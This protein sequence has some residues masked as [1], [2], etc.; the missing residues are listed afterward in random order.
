ME[1]SRVFILFQK[2]G[3]DEVV[4]AVAS[5]EE[6]ED[7]RS[8]GTRRIPVDKKKNRVQS[9]RERERE[10]ERERDGD[11]GPV[12]FFSRYGKKKVSEKKTSPRSLSLGRS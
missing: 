4:S 12:I 8:P 6:E 7:P 11:P 1:S 3:K 9:T 2:R 5:S 10:R